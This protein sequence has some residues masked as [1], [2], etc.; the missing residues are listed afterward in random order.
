MCRPMGLGKNNK[1]EDRNID[2]FKRNSNKN[3][4]SIQKAGICLRLISKY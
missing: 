1:K 2:T 4:W 3:L